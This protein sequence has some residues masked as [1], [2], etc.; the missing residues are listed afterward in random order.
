MYFLLLFVEN[1]IISC[2]CVPV[3]THGF[4]LKNITFKI[5]CKVGRFSKQSKTTKIL[6]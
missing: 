3:L 5:I 1:Y 4:E 2:Q 6:T